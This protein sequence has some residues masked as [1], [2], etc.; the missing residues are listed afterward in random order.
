MIDSIGIVLPPQVSL[1]QDL[2]N[3]VLGLAKIL[4]KHML[5]PQLEEKNLSIKEEHISNFRKLIDSYVTTLIK[6]QDTFI[7][8]YLYALNLYRKQENS[9]EKTTKYVHDNACFV[10]INSFNNYFRVTYFAQLQTVQLGEEKEPNLQLFERAYEFLK[11]NKLKSF[12]WLYEISEIMLQFSQKLANTIGKDI[13]SAQPAINEV[14]EA[15]IELFVN[16]TASQ[17]NTFTDMYKMVKEIRAKYTEKLCGKYESFIKEKQALYTNPLID[18]PTFIKSL[19]YFNEYTKSH[20]ER[21]LLNNFQLIYRIFSLQALILPGIEAIENLNYPLILAEPFNKKLTNLQVL[22]NFFHYLLRHLVSAADNMDLRLLEIIAYN[23]QKICGETPL[24]SDTDIKKFETELK[25]LKGLL[26]PFIQKSSG[27]NKIIRVSQTI[28]SLC[29]KAS[30]SDKQPDRFAI[31]EGINK[32]QQSLDAYEKLSKGTDAVSVTPATDNVNSLSE[33]SSSSQI[34]ADESYIIT[35]PEAAFLYAYSQPLSAKIFL[36]IISI[37]FNYEKADNIQY[38][39]QLYDIA[40]SQHIPAFEKLFMDMLS[41]S[42]LDMQEPLNINLNQTLVLMLLVLINYDQANFDQ[43]NDNFSGVYHFNQ[44]THFRMCELHNCMQDRIRL[45][46]TFNIEAKEA[47]IDTLNNFRIALLSRQKFLEHT[48][49]LLAIPDVKLLLQHYYGLTSFYDK[50]VSRFFNDPNKC[51][52]N[53]KDTKFY[54][55]L[56][57]MLLLNRLLRQR[58]LLPPILNRLTQEFI[59][60]IGQLETY[61]AVEYVPNTIETELPRR[62]SQ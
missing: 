54:N 44:A 25:V 11:I 21:G 20:F 31:E 23:A 39:L 59:K 17:V 36:N 42:K 7:E 6:Q 22:N 35:T 27:S 28:Q 56:L 10:I 55:M 48:L 4:N 24:L 15:V 45:L 32:I 53:I 52:I 38:I 60:Y 29:K 19:H 62:L 47:H 3:A 57:D 8:N 46:S 43:A 33:A 37:L 61:N 12:D 13:A 26:S 14:E 49:D 30:S 58:D 18:L 2:S 1:Q 34:I 5:A 9:I 40:N 51:N 41:G 50:T 16:A